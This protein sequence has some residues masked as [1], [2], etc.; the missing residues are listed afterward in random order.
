[1]IYLH[2]FGKKALSFSRQVHTILGDFECVQGFFMLLS[3]VQERFYNLVTC[4]GLYISNDMRYLTYIDSK[5]VIF[6]DKFYSVRRFTIVY[7][8]LSPPLDLSLNNLYY[9]PYPLLSSGYLIALRGK[10]IPSK[11]QH[12]TCSRNTTFH[13][14]QHIKTNLTN[15][16]E[17]K[18]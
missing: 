18:K 12:Y 15:A 2:P 4:T 7:R 16:V 1:M 14:R 3:S 9:I 8:D 17:T 10:D 11:H 5:H 13:S 6:V